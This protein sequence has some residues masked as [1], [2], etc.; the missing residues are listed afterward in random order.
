VVLKVPVDRQAE[1]ADRV[2]H[3]EVQAAQAAK[4]QVVRAPV[5]RAVLKVLADRQAEAADRVARR[6]VRVAQAVVRAVRPVHRDK[7]AARGLLRDS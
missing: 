2:A 6:E 7:P 5:E 4:A 3:R 1:A